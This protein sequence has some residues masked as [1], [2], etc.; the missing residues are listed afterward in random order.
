MYMLVSV[1]IWKK[2]YPEMEK[3]MLCYSTGDN[4][5]FGAFSL[6]LSA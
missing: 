3:G 1:L 5:L 2:V 4:T 6:V